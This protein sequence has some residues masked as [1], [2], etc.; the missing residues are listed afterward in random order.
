MSLAYDTYLQ[1]HRMNCIRGFDAIL[2]HIPYNV[3]DDIFD[4]IDRKSMYELLDEHDESKYSKMEYEA[5]DNYFYRGG[6]SDEE[7]KYTFD[8]AW[9]H[10]IHHNKHHWQYWVLI[11]DDGDV[12]TS[13]GK[14]KAL[15]MP[16]KYIIEMVCDWWTFSWKKSDSDGRKSSLG[17]IFT[18]YDEHKDKI[19]LSPATRT[20]V[21]KLLDAIR[22]YI[23]SNEDEEYDSF[24]ELGF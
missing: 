5:Y 2:N 17:E 10:H 19:I 4:N 15:D 9:L 18:W 3:I 7:G 23:V 14:V 20:K 1:T 12:L 22:K 24:D 11:E 21:E 6:Y 13:S 16:N 8:Y